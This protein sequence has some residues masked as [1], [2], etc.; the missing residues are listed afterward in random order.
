VIA[1]PGLNA[2]KIIEPSL[3]RGVEV[4]VIEELR[5]NV[6]IEFVPFETDM[7][8]RGTIAAMLKAVDGDITAQ[9]LAGRGE[10]VLELHAQ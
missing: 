4:G 9:G 1:G 5:R 10:T 7:I 8:L 2:S 6:E 3:R